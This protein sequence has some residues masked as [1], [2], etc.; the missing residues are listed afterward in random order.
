MNV[1]PLEADGHPLRLRTFVRSE[2]RLSRRAPG[3]G[4]DNCRSSWIWSSRAPHLVSDAQNLSAKGSPTPV[5]R[6]KTPVRSSW[7]GRPGPM[8]E[9]SAPAIGIRKG[10][11]IRARESCRARQYAYSSSAEDRAGRNPPAAGGGWTARSV[12]RIISKGRI[13][14]GTRPCGRRTT[15]CS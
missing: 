1:Q 14:V 4:R 12:G 6:A 3:R 10:I 2:E 8:S 7:S 11:S 15:V 13:G 5:G 9:A